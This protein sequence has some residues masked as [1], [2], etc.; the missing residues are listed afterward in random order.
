M[1]GEVQFNFLDFAMFKQIDI[2]NVVEIGNRVD[3]DLAVDG[4]LWLRGDDCGFFFFNVVG[5]DETIVVF[6]EESWLKDQ[7]VDF[8]GISEDVVV[9]VSD[10][11]H[12]L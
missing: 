2:V 9:F 11:F 8:I 3:V 7:F 10:L 4:G 6:A 1:F 12:E 5:M